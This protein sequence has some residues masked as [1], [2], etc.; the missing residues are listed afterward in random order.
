MTEADIRATVFETQ[1]GTPTRRSVAGHI[2]SVT[3]GGAN[4]ALR[5]AT[6]DNQG[7]MRAGVDNI[8]LIPIER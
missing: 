7:P 1:P 6:A 4:P 2:R 8:R 3:L 5:I